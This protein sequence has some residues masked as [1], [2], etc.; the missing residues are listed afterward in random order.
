MELKERFEDAQVRVKT[1]PSQGPDVLLKLY[2]L[3]KQANAGD[4][5]GKRPG[6]L[7]VKG[8]AKYD[9]WASRQ[10]MSQDAAMEE[11]VNYVDQLLASK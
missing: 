9:A 8:R 11:Y 3:F 6:M 2:G 5:T 4:V 1:L 10:G 7:D